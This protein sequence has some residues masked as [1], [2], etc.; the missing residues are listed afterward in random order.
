MSGDAGDGYVPV[1][2]QYNQGGSYPTGAQG[3]SVPT[4][5]A[6]SLSPDGAGNYGVYFVSDQATNLA[7]SQSVFLAPGSYDVGFD[8]YFTSNGFGQPGD[9]N[10]T[11]T[12]AGT[13]VANI[14]LDS[15]TPTVWTTH[16]GKALIGTAGFYNVSFVFNTPDAP[17]NAKD[18]VIDQ[19]YIVADEAGGGIPIS[20]VPEPAT[21]A[22][23]IFGF[24][25]IGAAT[26]S[27]DRAGRVRHPIISV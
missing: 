6:M 23:M 24:G 1:D 21:W 7:I 17:A 3:E 22:M 14:D 8:S 5:D 26:R 11:A 27:A 4:D 13:Q 10:L 19:A 15:I 25:V 9:A 2:I 20:P 12:I 16:T 18:V